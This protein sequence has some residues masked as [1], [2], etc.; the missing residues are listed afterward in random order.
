MPGRFHAVPAILVLIAVGCST[1]PQTA[2]LR[3]PYRIEVEHSGITVV[4]R[5]TIRGVPLAPGSPE[6]QAVTRWLQTHS[7]GWRLDFASYAPGRRI[8]GDGFTLNFLG[9]L[10]VLNADGFEKSL[11]LKNKDDIP[12]V[13]GP[14]GGAGSTNPAGPTIDPYAR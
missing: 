10:C 9:G 14:T 6:E 4:N 11:R 12:D 5:P 7:T 8:L 13:F 1:V 2:H 3:P